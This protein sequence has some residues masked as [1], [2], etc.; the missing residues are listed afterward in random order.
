M[1]RLIKYDKSQKQLWDGF[2]L[3]ARNSSFLHL[4]DFMEYHAHKFQDHSVLAYVEDKLVAVLPA[5]INQR[6]L[7]SHQ[8]L[9]YGGWIFNSK[10]S[11]VLMVELFTALKAYLKNLDII[12]LV[13]KQMPN[14][15]KS[16][17]NDADIYALNT[18]GAKIERMDVSTVLDMALPLSFGSQ[19]KR[20]I[21]KAQK[22]P[23]KV[24][25]SQDLKAYYAILEETLTRH[26]AKP[27]HSL[28]ELQRLM[29][30]FPENIKLY[31][32]VDH[33]ETIL[34]GTVIF[35]T[36]T[37]VHTQYL[38]NAEQGRILGALDYTLSV[39]IDKYK[40]T[41]RYFSFGTSM[42]AA[43]AYKFNPGLIGQKEGFGATSHVQNIFSLNCE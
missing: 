26:D 3:D 14:I 25:E 13:Y 33:N 1:I 7:Y 16:P 36:N 32:A 31:C 29:R 22:A 37:A 12:Q 35:I 43:F 24:V 5:N 2:V 4:R 6:V 18:V 28:E 9:T 23:L 11:Q 39:L 10:M 38:S 41:H 40:S 27:T 8:G 15:Y 21:K 19:R 20:N 34:A 17:I 42:D 30:L